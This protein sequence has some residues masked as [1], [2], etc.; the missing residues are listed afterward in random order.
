MEAAAATINA[1][2]T[3]ERH[4]CRRNG[5]RD[6]GELGCFVCVYYRAIYI[7]METNIPRVDT[8]RKVEIKTSPI[9][10]TE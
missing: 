3:R 4:R 6:E 7:R 10:K 2:A 1:V 9:S 8:R 5:L